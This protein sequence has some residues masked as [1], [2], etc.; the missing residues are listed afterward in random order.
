[1][2]TVT[3][4]G[5][6]AKTNG[7][8]PEVGSKA[9]GFKLT[10]TD[11]GIVSLSDFAGKKLVLNIFPSVDTSTC[12]AS[13]RQFN[14]KAGS[15]ENTAVLCISRDLP[16]AQK[17]FCG[18]EGLENVVSLSD[19]KDGSF[20]KDYGLEL[21]ESVLAG[22]HSRAVIVLDENGTVLHAEQVAEIADEPNYESALAVL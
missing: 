12:A 18:A 13:V 5:N 7:N 3:L 9:P 2:A 17:R 15:L 1:M 11:L 20:G 14:A 10:N 4:G 19:F 16:F 22:L 21:V 6:P 8:L